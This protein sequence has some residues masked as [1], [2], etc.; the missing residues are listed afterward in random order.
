MHLL[1]QNT[2]GRGG[3]RRWSCQ[4][5]SRGGLAALILTS[6]GWPSVKETFF[7]WS[8][9]KDS[10]PEVLKGF[11][12]D[13]KLFCI[14]EVCVLMSLEAASLLESG[15][16]TLSGPAAQVANDASVVAAYLGGA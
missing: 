6:N 1:L 12:L 10:F 4:D 9:F 16:I 11:W 15:R 3:S 5:E 14:V 7:S 8:A 2:I 13:I